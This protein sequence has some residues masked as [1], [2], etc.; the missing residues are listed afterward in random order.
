MMS[1]SLLCERVPKT[2]IRLFIACQSQDYS[3]QELFRLI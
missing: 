1:F 2:G 3:G